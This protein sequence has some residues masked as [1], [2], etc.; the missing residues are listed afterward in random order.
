[1]AGGDAL[2]L[3]AAQ[4]G[5]HPHGCLSAAS[6]PNNPSHRALGYSHH[7]RQGDLVWEE[8]SI[9][10]DVKSSTIPPKKGTSHHLQDASHQEKGARNV[11]SW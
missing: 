3:S 4:G 2:A 1:M 10:G 11:K 6:H 9:G 5:T 8:T 7:R